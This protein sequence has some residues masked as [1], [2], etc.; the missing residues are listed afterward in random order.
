MAQTKEY[1][2]QIEN[3]TWDVCPWGVDRAASAPLVRDAS[4]RFRAV[5]QE[6]LVI[7]RYSANWAAPVDQPINPWDLAEPDAARMGG[8]LPGTVLEGKVA[9][10]FVV[11]FRNNDQRA[12]MLPAERIHSLHCLLY[13]SPSP[14]DR[15]RSRMPSSA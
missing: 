12:G 9:D 5:P 1:W 10:D 3:H 8:T 15:T 13:T 2:L 11:H 7:R 4:G 14:R 6:V